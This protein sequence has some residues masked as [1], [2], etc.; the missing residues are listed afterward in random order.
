LIAP[1]RYLCPSNEK[2]LAYE[3]YQK[4]ERGVGM[5]LLGNWTGAATIHHA[6]KSC[7]VI[8]TH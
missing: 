1:L 5:T 4:V 8:H 6:A 2:V 7:K 3:H